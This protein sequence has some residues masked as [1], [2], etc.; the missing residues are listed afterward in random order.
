[1]IDLLVGLSGMVLILVAFFMNQTHR[2]SPDSITY[3]FANFIGGLLLVIY[4][5]M[6]SSYPFLIL[7]LVWTLISLRDVY[8]DLGKKEKGAHLHHKR[9]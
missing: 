5:L 7:N 9:K 6:I 4:A 1:M 8:L 3:D 2:W